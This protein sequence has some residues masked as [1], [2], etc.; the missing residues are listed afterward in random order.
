[1]AGFAVAP[2]TAIQAECHA[3]FDAS[4][5]DAARQK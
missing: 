4:L 1:M 3:F 2:M 5:S